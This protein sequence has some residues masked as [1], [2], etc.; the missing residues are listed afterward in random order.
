[1]QLTC[2]A[3][4]LS[5][6]LHRCRSFNLSYTSSSISINNHQY[7]S[8]SYVAPPLLNNNNNR[9]AGALVINGAK[10]NRKVGANV[11]HSGLLI[12]G[13]HGNGTQSSALSLSPPLIYTS[14]PF[15][16]LTI[17]QYTWPLSAVYVIQVLLIS[18]LH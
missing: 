14:L 3:A 7:A 13:S 4:G 5:A 18:L 15:F 11:R 10:Q 12:T 1:M 17:S 2:A 6:F 9:S 16:S 8:I